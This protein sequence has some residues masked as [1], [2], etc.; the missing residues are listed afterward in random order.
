MSGPE[1]HPD[2]VPLAA[3]LGTSPGVQGPQFSAAPQTG[4]AP[5]DV[6]GPINQ[7]FQG[8]LAN[9]NAQNQ[10]RSQT[11]G[12]IAGLAG[13]ALPFLFMPSDRRVKRDIVHVGWLRDLPLYAFRYVGSAVRQVGVMAQDVARLK[14]DAVVE[15]DGILHVNYGAL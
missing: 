4:I 8:Q 9:F 5:T 13:S 15:R 1:L 7:Q 11:L 12:S 10:A 14:P 6:I 2:C 3:L